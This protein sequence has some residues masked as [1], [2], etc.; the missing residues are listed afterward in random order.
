MPIILQLYV[1]SQPE[2]FESIA[3]GNILVGARMLL[4]IEPQN[5]KHRKFC[6]LTTTR[7]SQLYILKKPS[8]AKNKPFT[9]SSAVTDAINWR[10]SDEARQLLRGSCSGGYYDF[11]PLPP[12]LE[13]YQRVFPQEKPM[14]LIT[15]VNLGFILKELHYR[16]HIRLHIQGIITALE[17][18][19]AASIEASLHQTSGETSCSQLSETQSS[20]ERVR[21]K[22]PSSPTSQSSTSRYFFYCFHCHYC[23]HKRRTFYTQC[24]VSTCHNNCKWLYVVSQVCISY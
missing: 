7:E 10:Q 8:D 6:L 11:P 16:E 1:S 15:T 13:A 3:A 12:S 22:L 17:F 4:K 9:G 24:H 5:S 19:P 2:V 14:D 20:D 23:S 21:E 18:V